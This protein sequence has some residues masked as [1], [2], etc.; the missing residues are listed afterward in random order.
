MLDLTREG[1]PITGGALHLGG[2]SPQG[3]T[4]AFTNYYMTRNG[5]PT[6]PVMGEFHF[7]R[8]PRQYWEQELRKMQAGGVTIVASYIFWIHIEEEEGVFDWSGNNDLRGFLEACQAVNMP[9]LL[10][11]GPFNHGEGRNGGLPDWLYGRGLQ[12]RSNDERYLA[13]VRRLYRQ[14]SA[15]VKGHLFDEGGVVL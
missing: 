10:R 11:I 1:R 6:I 13:Y 9:I 2:T 15:Q 8:F 7:S 14:I 5:R 12:V 4:L 3:E